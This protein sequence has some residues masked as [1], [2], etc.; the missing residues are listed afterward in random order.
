MSD[1]PDSEHDVTILSGKVER[2]KLWAKCSCGRVW[3]G[4]WN[5][6]TEALH[7]HRLEMDRQ[8]ARNTVP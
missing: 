2:N 7:D 4:Y 1:S 6:L 3:H 5:S 8:A